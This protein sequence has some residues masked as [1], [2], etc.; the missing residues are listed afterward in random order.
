MPQTKKQKYA[1]IG[2]VLGKP[3]KG[4]KYGD[5]GQ[6]VRP[7]APAPVKPEGALSS[8]QTGLAGPLLRNVVETAADFYNAPGETLERVGRGALEFAS[9][10]DPAGNAYKPTVEGQAA[11]VAELNRRADERLP[12]PIKSMKAGLAIEE[13]KPRTT[14]GRVAGAAGSILGEVAF[15]TAPETAVVNIVTAPFAGAGVS[16]AKRVVAPVLR[17]IRGGRNVTAVGE[18]AAVGQM[19]PSEFPNT[20]AAQIRSTGA[21]AES[22]EV[23]GRTAVAPLETPGALP[24]RETL[25]E[26]PLLEAADELPF[27]VKLGRERA[28]TPGATGPRFDEAVELELRKKLD[29]TLGTKAERTPVLETISALRKAG[30]LT[31]LKTHIKN[32]GGTGA[33]QISEEL[34]RIPGAIADMIVSRVTG[35]RTLTGPSLGSMRRS[36]YEAAT[37]GIA[38]AKKALRTGKTKFDIGELEEIASGSKVI[39]AY[40][41]GVFRTLKAEDAVFRT[42]A[43]RRSLEDR[44]KALALTEM[45]QGKIPRGQVGERTREI[46][47]APPADIEAA[48][49]LDAEVATFNNSNVLSDAVSAGIQK[50]PKGGQFIADQIVPFRKT[51]TNV[52]ARI[53]ESSPA[54]YLQILGKGV[55]GGGRAIKGARA[56]RK[57]GEQGSIYRLAKEIAKKSFTEAEQRAFAQTFGR[58]SLGSGLIAL[59]YIGY[60]DGWLTG[61]QE[62]DPARRDRDTATGRAPGSIKVGNQWLQLTG[63]A[64]L[65][66]LLAIGATLARETAQ[67]QEGIGAL[68]ALEVAGQAV[69]EQ[70]LLIGT[71]QV[72]EALTK[73]GSVGEKFLGGYLGSTVP[74]MVSDV[75]EAF[76]PQQREATGITGRLQGR[77]PGVRNTLPAAQDVLGQPRQDVGP[78]GAFLDPT[79]SKTDAAS[80]SQLF[81][82]LVRLDVGLSGF[83][84][85][86]ETE[87]VYRQRVQELGQIYLPA[88]QQL[89]SSR[90]Y[91]W[92]SDEVK[93]E[94][95]KILNR[96]AKFAVKEGRNAGASLLPSSVIAAAASAVTKEKTK[97]NAAKRK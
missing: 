7:T 72:A 22:A 77:I 5:I 10:F 58:A 35:R 91:N 43:L 59:G 12:E 68:P 52:I 50:L 40:V 11:R 29:P 53:L 61:L 17:R 73:P 60:R 4:Q 46:L 27:E 66:P 78:V 67:E 33:F 94:A 88:G 9:A 84:K 69:A 47:K 96:R 3:P 81:A 44:A 80:S 14:A 18:N 2:Q 15:P 21:A 62:D 16:A 34:A 56:A 45:R 97:K 92:A 28:R 48:A 13:A 38:E 30:L 89:V 74:T 23:R 95:V 26:A 71:K 1:D 51:P 19:R 76:D 8:F 39:D 93:R 32:I 75:A 42:Y 55:I 20:T 83:D 82:E 41:N 31:G 79:R 63:F 49:L 90:E 6:I 87:E 37:D 24:V 65:G 25:S 36:A 64:P 70:P 86:G 57:A 85:E 54:G